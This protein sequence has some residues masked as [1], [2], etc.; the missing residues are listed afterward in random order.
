MESI[1]KDLVKNIKVYDFNIKEFWIKRRMRGLQKKNF[2]I[3]EFDV[4]NNVCM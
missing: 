1:D 4:Y 2:D 3:K